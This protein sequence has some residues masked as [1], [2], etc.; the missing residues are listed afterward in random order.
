MNSHT[1]LALKEIL[2]ALDLLSIHGYQTVLQPIYNL[3]FPRGQT[4]FNEVIAQ[5]P[6]SLPQQND[7]VSSLSTNFTAYQLQGLLYTTWWNGLSRDEP[8]DEN[9]N[10]I[11]DVLTKPSKDN[12]VNV[13]S[14]MYHSSSILLNDTF[15]E[16]FNLE[17]R[18]KIVNERLTEINIKERLK[19]H[20]ASN[21]ERKKKSSSRTSSNNRSVEAEVRSVVYDLVDG[22]VNSLPTKEEIEKQALEKELGELETVLR[23]IPNEFKVSFFLFSCVSK[24]GLFQNLSQFLCPNI[25]V[26]IILIILKFLILIRALFTSYNFIFFEFFLYRIINSLRLRIRSM[27][28]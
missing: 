24:R 28:Y 12:V 16:L 27:F 3:L 15:I 26:Q 8:R 19:Q 23:K 10:A 1:S 4:S 7:V 5:V 2:F 22:V 20:L 18:C 11:K 17:E 13:I 21:K 14:L 9:H 6:T 25:I